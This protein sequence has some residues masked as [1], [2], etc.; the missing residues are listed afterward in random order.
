MVRPL[1]LAQAAGAPPS[2]LDMLPVFIAIGLIWWFVLLRP[3]RQQEKKHREMLEA[4]S[5][6]QKVVT[7]GGIYGTIAQLGEKTLKLKVADNVRI[8]VSRSSIAGSQAAET[9]GLEKEG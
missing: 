2:V 1:A 7:Q 5:V 8:E 6:G 9:T 3:Q 4:L